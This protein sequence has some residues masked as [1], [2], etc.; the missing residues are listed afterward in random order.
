MSKISHIIRLEHSITVLLLLGAVMPY[1]FAQSNEYIKES[2]S[3]H[4]SEYVILDNEIKNQLDSTIYWPL[5]CDTL[6]TIERRVYMNR[7]NTY[8]YCHLYIKQGRDYDTYR[9]VFSVV[10]Y[11]ENQIG[12]FS[13]RDHVFFIRGDKPYY[14]V[15]SNNKMS[16]SYQIT[17]LN[18][19]LPLI[20]L[21]TTKIGD[22]IYQGEDDTPFMEFVYM[23]HSK[24]FR[25]IEYTDYSQDEVKA[26]F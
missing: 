8:P 19:T 5:Y 25:I 11:K 15:Q 2:I 6:T 9:L 14:F 13:L 21:Y 4:A 10:P 22:R 16:F 26:V 3:F 17:Y 1:S 7:Y 12:F 24:S 23:H 20:I 18:S